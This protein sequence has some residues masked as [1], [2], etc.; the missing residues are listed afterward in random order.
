MKTIFVAGTDTEVGKTYVAAKLARELRQRNVRVGVYKPVAS[1]CITPS[2]LI[3]SQ[4]IGSGRD[5]CEPIVDSSGP[6]PDS[7]LQM[8][9]ISTDALLLWQAAG[10]PLDLAAVCPQRFT[11]AL[12]P[13]VAAEQAGKAVDPLAFL[14]ELRRWKEI[15]DVLIVEGAG[16]LFS[17]LA[18]SYLN[19]DL[20]LQLDDPELV[21]VSKNRLGVM[22]QVISTCEAARGRGIQ[23]SRVLLTASGPDGDASSST[24]VGELRKLLPHTEIEEIPW[25]G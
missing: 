14:T 21:I 2:E 15:S 17:P 4:P 10:Q 23:V 22:H 24:N 6:I 19:I 9:L 25:M 16:G 3:D 11:A 5:D 8:D 20:V 13:H 12:A 7:V 1:D 18:D